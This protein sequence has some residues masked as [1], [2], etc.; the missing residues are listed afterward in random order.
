MRL[1]QITAGPDRQEWINL[2]AVTHVTY[3][4]GEARPPQLELILFNGVAE[5]TDA[6]EIKE[7]ALI[8]GI[9]IPEI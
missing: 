5:V 3:M 8:L 6:N 4:S 1:F 2:D 7:I 9:A